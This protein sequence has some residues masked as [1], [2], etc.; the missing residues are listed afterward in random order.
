MRDVLHV[1]RATIQ[2]RVPESLNLQALS[3]PG[4][5]HVPQRSCVTFADSSRKKSASVRPVTT[6][7]F[8]SLDPLQAEVAEVHYHVAG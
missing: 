4:T 7:C 1:I 8:L 5:L 3:C 6:S 2:V